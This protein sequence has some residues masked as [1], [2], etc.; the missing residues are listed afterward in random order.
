MVARVSGARL[1]VSLNIPFSTIK[2]FA[3]NH[4]L[5][6]AS[7]IRGTHLFRG[8]S[9]GSGGGTLALLICSTA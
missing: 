5:D 2:S 3:L 9:L 8:S 4:L 7:R 1:A 6:G